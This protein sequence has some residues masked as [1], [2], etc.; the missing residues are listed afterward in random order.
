MDSPEVDGTLICHFDRF[1]PIAEPGTVNP[2]FPYPSRFDQT[3]SWT[4]LP[5]DIDWLTMVNYNGQQ[6]ET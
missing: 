6:V 4:A 3:D 5:K 1:E 2:D